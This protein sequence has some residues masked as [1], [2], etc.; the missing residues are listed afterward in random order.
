M[1]GRQTIFEF[2]TREHGHV[3][4]PAQPALRLAESGRELREPCIA[5]DEQV[6]IAGGPFPR[7]RHG[8][9]DK[10][11]RDPLR[12]RLQRIA[13]NIGE[14]RRFGEK[15]GQFGEKSALGIRLV[16]DPIAFPS[17]PENPSLQE[18]RQLTLETGR[19]H[20]EMPRE[21][22]PVPPAVRIEERGG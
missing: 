2:S 18:G 13:Q 10:G 5:N 12:E 11:Q 4:G 7:P 15:T 3:Y 1:P 8:A 14:P 9:V 21:V 16:I 17:L 20:S 19:R 6:H 22:T